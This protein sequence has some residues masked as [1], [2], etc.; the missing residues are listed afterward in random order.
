MP[1][2][3]IEKIAQ[4]H[5]L[6]LPARSL[7]RSGDFLRVRPAHVMTHDNTGAVIPKFEGI[8]AAG[9]FDAR[10]PVF[11]LDH[12]VQNRSQANL[13]KYERIEAFAREQGVEFFG[14]GRGIG[15]QVMC[16]EGFVLPG[17]M[18]VASDSH[19]NLY[20]GLGAL[21]TPVVRT[22]AAALWAVGET[23]YQI[24]PITR[25]HLEGSLAAG[26]SGK[27]VIITLCGR[28]NEDEVLNHGLEFQGPGVATLSIDERLAIAN[29]TTEW[30]A[31]AGVFACDERTLDWLDA[32]LAVLEGEGRNRGDLDAERLAALRAEPPAA[33]GDAIY[34][35]TITLDLSQVRRGVSGPD[36]VKRMQPLALLERERIPVHKA[37]ILSCVNGRA[38]DLSAAARVLDG[39]RVAEGVELYVAA[40]SSEV[41]AEVRR[42]GDWERLER[43]GAHFLPPGCGPCIGLGEGLLG[44]DEVGISATNRNFKGRMGARSAR[45]YLASPAVVAQSAIAGTICGGEHDAPAEPPGTLTRHERAPADAGGV[46]LREGFAASLTGDVLFLDADNLNTDGIYGK[47]WTYQ[48]G[49]T[50]EEMASHSMENYDPQFLSIAKPGD[51][52]VGGYNFG[53]GSSREQAVTCLSFFGIQCVIAASFSETYKRN[54]FNNGFLCIDCPELVERLRGVYG[55]TVPTRRCDGALQVDF[56]GS[57]LTYDGESYPISRLGPAAQDLILAGG[58][59]PLVRSKI[60]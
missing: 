26:V 8:G 38:D 6:D 7:V 54:A 18:V 21:G 25:V 55:E 15:H 46:E 45:C 1:Q 52:I 16:E 37:Y 14:A 10:Q 41:E 30:G 32:R 58:L 44:E 56:V 34:R 5:A 50:P 48:D 23:W 31:L 27:D 40:A 28:F 51:V 57:K 12:D 35:Q 3:L 42:R 60:A 9:V 33:D 19:S 22:D 29:M 36:H 4:S 20:G 49:L 47:D 24:P 43:A 59:E 2:T 53:T 17:T 11:T 39:K 13:E